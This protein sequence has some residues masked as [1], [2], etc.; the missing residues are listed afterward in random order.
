MSSQIRTL[1]T[2]ESDFREMP[3]SIIHEI[4]VSCAYECDEINKEEMPEARAELERGE[5][6]VE[7]EYDNIEFTLTSGHTYVVHTEGSYTEH[8]EQMLDMVCDDAEYDAGSMIE[9]TYLTRYIKF[10][11]EAFAR[12]IELGGDLEELVACYDGCIWEIGWYELTPSL[13]R[14]EEL[15]FWRTY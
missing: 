15:Y 14:R 10:D 6:D 5:W 7:V 11:R 2:D 3:D 13:Q 12:D 8:Q 9:Q 4:L 1:V